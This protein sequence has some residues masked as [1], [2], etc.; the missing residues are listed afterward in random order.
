M[1]FK[2]TPIKQN[3]LF[4]GFLHKITPKAKQI[5]AVGIPE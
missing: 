5:I 3:K 4:I 1:E 2:K